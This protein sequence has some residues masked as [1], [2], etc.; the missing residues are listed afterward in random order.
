MEL[1][2]E[3]RFRAGW[4]VGFARDGREV[5]ILVVKGTFL[6][7]KD[8]E[9]PQI[10]EEQL[11]LVEADRFTG[12]PG[13]SA[14]LE[15]V[16][17]AHHK[18]VCDVLLKGSAY[19]PG[20]RPVQRVTVSLQVGSSIEKSFDVVGNREWDTS[21]IV[22]RSTPP[23][24]FVEMPITYDRAFG[25]TDHDSERPERVATY[26]KNPIG[27]GYYPLSAE[28]NLAGRPLPNSEE[29]GKPVSK[30]NDQ[31][32]PMSFGPI[33]RNFA[34]R[35]PLAGTYDELWLDSR[36]PFWPED[37]D[38][39]YFQAAPRDQQMPYPTGGEQVVLRNLTP[40]GFASWKLPMTRMPFSIVRRNQAPE[41]RE[42]VIDTIFI[43]ADASQFSMTWRLGVP[44]KRDCFEIAQVIAGRA[45]SPREPSPGK[46]HFR[47]IAEFI[48]WKRSRGL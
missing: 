19:A 22:R 30:I 23:Q 12:E 42:A 5:L 34:A 2:N 24:T 31:Y 26:G 40:T 46:P 27:V 18:P 29:R 21:L 14:I 8:E 47:S 6:F 41:V 33:G 9:F 25:G 10:A 20:G 3:T 4:T 37:F 7:P 28:K 38:Y 32:E 43:D 13:K 44:L 11:Q 17:Y 48:E 1:V 16:D 35:Y 45:V 39:R 15:E 36:A